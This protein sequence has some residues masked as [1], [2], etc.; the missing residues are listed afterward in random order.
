MTIAVALGALVGLGVFLIV[1]GVV[2]EE[3]NVNGSRHASRAS[4]RFP[5]TAGAG[6]AP[7]RALAALA[8]ALVVFLTTGWPAG[9]ALASLATVVVPRVFVGHTR[10]REAVAKTEAVAAWAEMLRDTMA[11]AAGI[12]EAIVAT[13]D[14]APRPIRDSVIL[15]AA[16]LDRDRLGPALRAFA[17]EMADPA[18][19]LVVTALTLASERHARDLGGL[20]SALVGSARAEAAM[21]LRVEAGRSRLRTAAKIVVATTLGF[22]ALLVALNRAFLAPYDD[23]L[24]QAWLLVVGGVF[25]LGIRELDRMARIEPRPRVFALGAGEGKA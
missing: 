6:A 23:A 16:R 14:V 20:L 22:A 7:Q 2:G 17:D 25:A 10:D 11:G 1:A 4:H 19:D 8:V 3:E 13:A 9:A 12:E 15:L 18:A 5:S 24:G 21:R